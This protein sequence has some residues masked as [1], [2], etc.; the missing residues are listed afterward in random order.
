MPGTSEEVAIDELIDEGLSATTAGWDFDRFAGRMQNTP[1]EWDYPGMCAA[2]VQPGPV[3]DMGTGGGEQLA[4]WLASDPPIDGPVVA[5]EG[6]P[7]NVPVAG[8]RLH[9][10][11]V[12]VVRVAGATD[13]IEQGPD[14][15]SGRLPFAADSF[16]TILSRNE[17]Y[18]AA[19]VA[20][21]LRPGGTF[22]TQQVGGPHG[23]RDVGSDL[24][25]AL[26]LPPAPPAP[27]GGQWTLQFAVDQAAAG[28]LT[29]VDAGVGADT[30][31]YHDIAPLVWYLRQVPWVVPEL[32]IQRDRP[33]LRELGR[34][35]DRDG[36]LRVSQ[37]YFWLRAVLRVAAPA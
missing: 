33:R 9:P 12:T 36:P 25:A 24:R 14:D 23:T 37:A 15:R 3:L 20:R 17:A 4:G 21:V 7:P 11:G 6:W 26:G 5:T 31:V 22:L 35:I 28:G 16:G 19:E 34:R 29:V 2:A 32:D 10:L 27:S 18:R 1:P 30:T 8:R 13:N